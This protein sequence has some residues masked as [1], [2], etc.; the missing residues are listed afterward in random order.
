M[1]AL[2]GPSTSWTWVLTLVGSVHI[3]DMSFDAW[4][5]HFVGS[6]HFVDLCKF[7]NLVVRP[8]RGLWSWPLVGSVHF[9]DLYKFVTLVGSVHFV[10]WG[11]DPWWG[12]STLWTQ[13]CDP[14]WVRPFCGL[15][16]LPLVGFV[17]FVDL[18][19]FVTLV[20]SVH[21][22]DWSRPLVGSVH[23]MDLY[24]FDPSWVRPLC[25]LV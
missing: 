7:E 11:L 22:M 24:K 8:L 12:P 5:I 23:F 10:D 3:V 20:G 16:S 1:F 6:V 9:V 2:L 18:Y 4:S 25:G 14:G 21:F 17:H 15:G 13:V 19:K